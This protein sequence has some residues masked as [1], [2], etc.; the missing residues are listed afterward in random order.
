[1]RPEFEGSGVDGVA[2]VL[3]HHSVVASLRKAA[4]PPHHTLPP[5]A[6]QHTPTTM[7]LEGMSVIH[8]NKHCSFALQVETLHALVVVGNQDGLIGVGQ[9]SGKNIQKVMLDAQL[10]AYKNLVAIPRYRGHTVY[11]PIDV[12]VRKVRGVNRA[13]G[14]VT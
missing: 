13:A 6:Q 2:E 8:S 11:H 5:N 9:H 4:L 3:S 7:L 10:K 14:G 12:T 1:M